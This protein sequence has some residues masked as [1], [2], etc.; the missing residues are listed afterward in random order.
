MTGKTE[1]RREAAST[2]RRL[3]AITYV[4]KHRDVDVED[5]SLLELSRV[6]NAVANHL[7]HR[8]ADRLGKAAV[9]EG[10][11]VS[12]C[13]HHHVMDG[14]ING[15]GGHARPHHRARLRQHSRRQ[16]T[17][18][19]HGVQGGARVNLRLRLPGRVLA[20][21]GVGRSGD[22]GRDRVRRTHHAWQDGRARQLFLSQAQQLAHAQTKGT[23]RH[24]CRAA[25]WEQTRGKRAGTT[26]GVREASAGHRPRGRAR[27]TVGGDL[28]HNERTELKY[29]GRA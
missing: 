5:V 13:L 2:T 22:V 18:R 23:I 6:G 21:L 10:R 27:G 3:V 15:V 16:A 24:V 14:P 17:G 29:C 12:I 8:G 26:A 19:A 20:R 11:G 28:M 7:V 25:I 4:Q 1:T 9:V